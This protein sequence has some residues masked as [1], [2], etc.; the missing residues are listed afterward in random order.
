MKIYIILFLSLIYMS[1]SLEENNLLN[2]R[3]TFKE[4]FDLKNTHYILNAEEEYK[5]NQNLIKNEII[6][7]SSAYSYEWSNHPKNLR[8][9]LTSYL[10]KA[11]STGHRD[12]TNYDTIYINIYS[13]KILL[14]KVT[15]IIECQER[16]PDEYSDMK[17]SYK[18][19]KIPMDFT[20]WKEIKI[21]YKQLT[22]SYGAD[23]KRV[24][25]LAIYSNGWGN[26]PN[27]ETELFID[28]I[29]FTKIKYEF[30]MA[31]SE[32]L[33]ENYISILQKFKYSL[34]GSGSLLN[35]K[36]PDIIKRFENMVKTSIRTHN[37]MN[38]TGLPFDYPM[39]QS[40]DI[41]SIY[42]K[43]NEMVKGYAIEGSEIYKNK[44]FFNDIIYC[45]DYMH[46]KYFTKRYP[47]QFKGLDNWWHWEIGIPQLLVEMIVY[48]KDELSQEKINKYLIPI[49][50][51]IF[52]P[53]LTFANR[54][55]IAYSC[56]I[57][58]VLQK[59]YK[60]IALSVEML[61][62]LF[63]NVEIS[64]GF[65]E[66]GSFIQHEIYAYAGAYGVSLINSLSRISYILDDTCFRL[67]DYM[68]E[69]Q[70][71]W[72]I[73]SYIPFLYDGAFFDL[74][75]GRD[76]T[77]NALGLST[78]NNAIKS[79]TFA[80]KYIKDINNLTKLKS[81]LKYIYLRHKDYYIN[82]LA[83]ATI[84]LLEE[85]VSDKSIIPENIIHNFSKL[86]SRMDKAI[87]QMNN[88]GIGFSFSSTRNGKYESI[89]GENTIGWYQGDG[90]VYIYLSPNDYGKSYWPYANPLRLP[91][92]TITNAPR[93]KK[94]LSDK[95]A[96]AKY[97]FVGGCYN[98]INMVAAMKFASESTGI[99]FN[100]SLEGNKAYFVFENCLVFIGNNI[101][102]NDNYNVETIIENRK[103]YGK[104]YF[105][106][107]EVIDKFGDITDNYIYIENYGSIYIPEYK[108]VK[109]NI[110]NNEFIELY[111]D[112]GKN[113]QNE[114]YIYFI[115][116]NIDSSNYQKYINN[117]QILVD[118]SKITAVKNKLNNIFEIVFWEK[119]SFDKIQVDNPCT[120]ILNE[121]KNEFYISSPNHKIDYINVN[122]GNNIYKLNLKNGYTYR[123]KIENNNNMSKIFNFP[124]F[125]IILLS[126][127]I[128]FG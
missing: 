7:N 128:L 61:R 27:P 4:T 56:I 65:Y 110:T 109:Y 70:Y 116:P 28:K 40:L 119:G 48:L 55:D 42:W 37:I 35:E 113:I 62:E 79:F 19:Y 99:N 44:E 38:R 10:P 2:K 121:N 78:G 26:T 114:K 106:N 8:I 85:I 122:I 5:E 3:L 112:H 72:I 25:G 84:S 111:F 73:N 88:V 43:T 16:T 120:I 18:S 57:A 68:K 14:T 107:M 123:V 71:N 89:N 124:F 50:E 9:R 98:D 24:S 81:Y 92:T 97:D 53:K 105:G 41:Y 13:K 118:N 20:G 12:M 46:E 69:K 30:N 6:K 29:C 63:N 15:L 34:I 17:V 60:R 33:E 74:V 21:N 83:I 11:D 82:N 108:K 31:E 66:D 86:Y 101:T 94:G 127:I 22:D 58:G 87:T 115:L 104:L 125:Y 67:D 54:A 76:A 90:M 49:N 96:L 80:T 95:N 64:D 45:L 36:N 117:I 59:D 23:M 126:L 77:R 91:G 32:I 103:L 47:R 52:Y 100:S 1:N 75:R 102:C 39:E 51:Y 93:E